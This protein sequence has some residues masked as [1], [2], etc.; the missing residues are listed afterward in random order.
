M[1]AE[2]LYYDNLHFSEPVYRILNEEFLEQL[3]LLPK[4]YRK[5]NRS[6]VLRDGGV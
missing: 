3:G 4:S 6:E 2:E 1:K 5:F